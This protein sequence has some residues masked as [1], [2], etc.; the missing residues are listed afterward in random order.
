M[1]PQRRED[2]EDGR[3]RRPELVRGDRDVLRA[4]E[5][6]PPEPFDLTALL[7]SLKAWRSEVA[8]EHNLP[9]YVVFH[10]A[11]LIEMARRRPGSLEELAH[12]TGVGA[13]KLEAYGREILRVLD[14]S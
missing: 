13:K 1:A 8:R 2:T 6:H 7:A 12:I 11:T 10:D 14:A 9:A 4:G 3:E 5:I